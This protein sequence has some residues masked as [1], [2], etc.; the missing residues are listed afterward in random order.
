[1]SAPR[2]FDFRVALVKRLAFSVRS[3][4]DVAFRRHHHVI[5]VLGEHRG[6]EESDGAQCFLTDINEVVFYRRWNGKNAPRADTV[7]VAIFHV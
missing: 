2:V 4:E 5:E 1:V 6:G 3:A 7:G